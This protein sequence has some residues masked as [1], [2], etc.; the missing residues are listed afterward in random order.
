MRRFG[1]NWARSMLIVV[2]GLMVGRGGVED[3]L[4]LLGSVHDPAALNGHAVAYDAARN[5]AV[6][7]S[8]SSD[9]LSVVSL[10]GNSPA[11]MGRLHDRTRLNGAVHATADGEGHALVAAYYSD[12]LTV[13]DI[14]DPSNP[15][16]SGYLSDSQRLDGATA[17]P[18]TTLTL[19]LSHPYPNPNPD[20]LSRCTCSRLRQ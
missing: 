5:L 20:P 14:S 12:A 10:S 7:P 1:A 18:P 3:S 6:L 13:V 4:L 15:V 9:T 17:M 19:S 2:A 16:V 8:M 11:V